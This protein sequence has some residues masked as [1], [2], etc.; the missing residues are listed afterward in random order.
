[1]P[2]FNLNRLLEGQSPLAPT[3]TPLELNRTRSIPSFIRKWGESRALLDALPKDVVGPVVQIDLDRVMGG[4]MPMSARETALALRAAATEETTIDRDR[5]IV[6]RFMDDFQTFTAAL[7]RLPLALGKEVLS[8]PEVPD[9][10]AENIAEGDVKGILEAPGVRLLPGAYV[11]AE[12]RGALEHPLFALLDVAPFAR[13]GAPAAGRAVGRATRAVIP[14]SAQA[15]LRTVGGRFGRRWQASQF[16]SEA[17]ETARALA[18]A[19][20]RLDKMFQEHQARLR[21]VTRNLTDNERVYL[22][23]VM[24]TGDPDVLARLDPK[25][26]KIIDEVRKINDELFTKGEEAGLLERVGGEVYPKSAAYKL[27]QADQVLGRKKYNEG[28]RKAEGQLETLQEYTDVGRLLMQDLDENTLR[29]IIRSVVEE[30]SEGNLRNAQNWRIHEAKIAAL[31]KAG[32]TDFRTQEVMR[33]A[34]RVVRGKGADDVAARTYQARRLERELLRRMKEGAQGPPP[35]MA[36]VEFQMA[37]LG[38]YADSLP[39]SHAKFIAMDSKAGV[40]N[41]KMI[42]RVWRKMF[43]EENSPY[44]KALREIEQGKPDRAAKTLGRAA[45]KMLERYGV[46]K[47]AWFNRDAALL[48]SLFRDASWATQRYARVQSAT[49]TFAKYSAREAKTATRV[50]QLTRGREKAAEKYVKVL[51][52][53]P[54]ARFMPLLDRRLKE[55]LVQLA[56]ERNPD[57]S[58]AE[59]KAIESHIAQGW[60]DLVPNVVQKDIIGISKELAATWYSLKRAGYD[61]TFVHHVGLEQASKLQQ[62]KLHAETILEPS[63]VK[64]RTWNMKPYLEDFQFGMSHQGLEYLIRETQ[65]TVIDQLARTFGRP[66][67]Q[68]LAEY[69]EYAKL[70]HDTPGVSKALKVEELLNKEWTQWD[71]ESIIPWRKARATAAVTLPGD[72]IIYI[73]KHVERVIREMMPNDKTTMGKLWDTSMGV[74]RIGVLSLSPRWHVYNTVGG[75][76]MLMARTGPTAWTPSRIKQAYQ[77]VRSGEIPDEISRGIGSVPEDVRTWQWESGR[78]IGDLTRRHID[79]GRATEPF[80]RFVQK[81]FDL[82]EGVDAFYRSLA[83]LYQRDKAVTKGLS[84]EAAEAEGVR[85]ANKILQDWDD[86]VPI[87]RNIIRHIMPFYGWL[88]HI[89]QYTTTYPWDHPVRAS[90]IGNLARNEMADWGEG[91]PLQFQHYLSLGPT[92]PY[93]KTWAVNIRG[94]NPWSDVANFFSLAGFFSQMNPYLQGLAESMGVNT[95]SG[96]ARLFPDLTYDYESG[97]LAAETPGVLGTFQHIF[98]SFSPQLQ[99]ALEVNP[100]TRSQRMKVLMQQEPSRA[101]GQIGTMFGVP[102]TP[103]RF[104]RAEEAARSEL[105]RDTAMRD[106]LS[107]A[108]QTGDYS[109]ANRYAALR[110]IL[111]NLAQLPDERLAPFAPQQ[112]ESEDVIPRLLRQAG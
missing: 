40:R 81:S 93:G 56:R 50:Q 14:E 47:A 49:E 104:S 108:I 8:L 75:A 43:Q 18:Q 65:E 72:E 11:A 44:L 68:L 63:Q 21:N 97:R 57:I 101:W 83:Y 55:R 76:A 61:P 33:R 94:A 103:R 1:M 54:P 25:Y 13:F 79:L 91:V 16:G 74:F 77:M 85:L 23:Q 34:H 37:R 51:G 24:E 15:Y 99:G 92:D 3:T 73:P 32:L 36:A 88:K 2:T 45:E 62:P 98:A 39:P 48:H 12:G 64:D 71:P 90:I 105:A 41:A 106:V 46:P 100:W 10:I 86:M 102:F 22:T 82:N 5:N 109:Q 52:T 30:V 17:R 38:R 89:I 31:E 27:R 67:R 26:T 95:L 20:R 78:A 28:L 60:Y 66:R 4:Q 7:P 59:F 112:L 6:E 69:E 42:E 110:P 107:R 96:S 84:K 111:E 35:T 53:T 58:P 70:Y 9:I 87:E 80:K 29:G 19:N